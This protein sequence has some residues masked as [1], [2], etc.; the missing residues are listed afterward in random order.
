ML[1][2]LLP[3]GGFCHSQTQTGACI[4]I[5]IWSALQ[6]FLQYFIA[7]TRPNLVNSALFICLKKGRFFHV[8]IDLHSHPNFK[9]DVL[10]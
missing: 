9:F 3:A 2:L 4:T 8:Y 7:L 10:F 5:I 1:L 6:T